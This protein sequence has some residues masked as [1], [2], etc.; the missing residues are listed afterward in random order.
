MH[1]ARRDCGVVATC[2]Q[3]F[4]D[5]PDVMGDEEGDSH[6]MLFAKTVREGA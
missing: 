3:V 2:C 1:V 5:R 6:K 4:A